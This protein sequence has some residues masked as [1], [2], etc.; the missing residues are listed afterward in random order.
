MTRCQCISADGS[1]GSIKHTSTVCMEPAELEV[2]S[3]D[4]DNGTY[5]FCVLCAVEARKSSMFVGV[6]R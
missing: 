5:H 1:C 4:W 3:R 2:Q 6:G